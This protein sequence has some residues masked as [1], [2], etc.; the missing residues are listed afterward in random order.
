[1]LSG[2]LVSI[3]F[4][5]VCGLSLAGLLL[6]AERRILRF[7]PCKIDINDGKQVLQVDGG[8]DLLS[9]LAGN[10]LF[11]PSACGGRGTCAYCK[12]RVTE[13]GGDAGPVETPYL[14]A[15][16][17]Q[18]DVRLACQV[19]VRRDMRIQMPGHLFNIRRF[20]GRVAHKKPLTGDIV[21]LRIELDDEQ[22]IAFKAGQYIQLASRPYRG[23]DA[24]MRAYSISS[25]PSETRAVETVIRL[26]PDGICTT[27]VF[28]LLQQ[29]DPVSFSGPY[30][31]FRLSATDRPCLFIAGGSGMAPIWSMLRDMRE[32]G[33]RRPVTYFFGALTR[34]DLFYLDQLRRLERDAD[35]FRFVP[36]LSNEPPDSPW[37]GERGL[38]TDVIARHQ[39]DARGHEAYL[40]GSPGMIDAAVRV[41][42]AGG[43]PEDQVFYDKFA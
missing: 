30:G 15:E 12:V 2:I 14:S 18:R 3:A 21:E 33:N 10:E 20:S 38:I 39:P 43:M 24:V 25:P 36:A 35:W 7:G 1:M 6:L 17:I 23:R 5:T 26:V 40:C 31:D 16:E 34:S 13:G 4:L 22:A 27:W 41:L 11:L 9:A 8:N 37:R 42:T 32:S 19:R 28:D 29:G